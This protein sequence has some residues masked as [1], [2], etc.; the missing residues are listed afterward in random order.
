MFTIL[1]AYLDADIR[2]ELRATRGLVR[3]AEVFALSGRE[4]S[5]LEPL[6]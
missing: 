2:L 6:I 3:N 5:P 1:P 4:T